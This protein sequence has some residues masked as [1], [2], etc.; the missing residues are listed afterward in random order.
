MEAEDMIQTPENN[1]VE[2]N[3]DCSGTPLD[4]DYSCSSIENY[5]K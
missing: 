5:I 4:L 2:I 3:E 1:P